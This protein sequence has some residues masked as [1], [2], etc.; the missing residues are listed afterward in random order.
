MYQADYLSEVPIVSSATR[1]NQKITEVPAAITIID[2]E[3]IEASGA[4]EIPQ[5]FRLVPGYLSYYVFGNQFGVT[6]RGLTIEF[7]GD[8]EVMIDGRS[9]YEPIFS[10]VEWSSL[11]I[12]VEDIEYIEVLRGSNTPAYGS[13]A[14]LGAINIVTTNPVQ[15]QGTSLSVTL[16]DLQT[17]NSRIR[18]NGRLGTLNYSLG[19]SFRSNDGFPRLKNQS[20]PTAFDK[21]QDSNQALHLNLKLIYTPSV[22]D[23]FEFQA[24]V[25]ESDIDIPGNDLTD[26]PKGFNER[27]L[28]SSYQFLRWHRNLQNTNELQVQLYHNRLEVDEVRKLGPLS[29]LLGV[30]PE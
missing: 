10:A 24:G 30:P 25:G 22:F 21:I 17:R 20:N 29:G 5:L 16:G 8:L 4:T 19:M 26:G 13:N 23:T 7:P 9:V 11:G 15:A 1:L 2:R 18:H 6:N 3:M 12:T 14:Y 27:E 28:D